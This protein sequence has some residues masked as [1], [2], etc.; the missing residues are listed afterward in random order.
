MY[1]VIHPGYKFS[2]CVES[3][4]EQPFNEMSLEVPVK[5]PF[6]LLRQGVEQSCPL[7]SIASTCRAP[8]GELVWQLLLFLI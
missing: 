7:H 3:V 1:L 8:A 6:L 2:N 4:L 5:D